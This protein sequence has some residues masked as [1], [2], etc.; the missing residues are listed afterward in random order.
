[1]AQL[2]FEAFAF[3][4]AAGDGIGQRDADEKRKGGLDGVMKRA[5][6]PLHMTLV[7]AQEIPEPISW[8]GLRHFGEAQHFGHHQQH[9]ESAIRIDGDVARRGSRTP[10]GNRRRRGR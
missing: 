10:S 5:A 1:M 6:R 2:I 3:G 9:D 4:G 7:I 8:E